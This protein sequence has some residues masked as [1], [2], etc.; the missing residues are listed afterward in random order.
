LPPE[1]QH[2]PEPQPDVG[3]RRAWLRLPTKGSRWLSAI[4]I[5]A[6]AYLYVFPLFNRVNNPNENVRFYMTA[7]IVED[8]TYH[9]DHVRERWG[10]VNDAAIYE[11]H[12]CSV[13]APATSMLGVPAY[14][15]YKEFAELRGVPFDRDVAL[16]ACRVFASVLPSLLFLYFYYE[17]LRRRGG[18]PVVRDAVFMSVAVGSMF[19][20]YAILFVTHTL[21][22]VAAFGA[23]MILRDARHRGTIG[24][25]SAWLAGFLA[26][27]I[28]ATEYP[29]APATAILCIYA[30]FCVRPLPRILSFGVG[31]L[32]PTLAVMHFHNSCYGSPF[33]PGH[34]FLEN[35]EFRDAMHEGFYGA[36]NIHWE[37]AGGLLFDPAYGLF[38]VT[39]ILFFAFFGVPRLLREKRDR[40]DVWFALAVCGATYAFICSVNNWR[41]GWTVGARY[42]ALTLPFVG[43][44]ALEGGRALVRASWM[45]RL[46]GAI[47][48][49]LLGG[50]ILLSG[51]PS[52]YYPHLPEAFTRPLPQ[53]V[54]WLVR[55]DYAP[56]N[57][58]RYF[59]AW[60]GSHSMVPLFIVGALA[61]LWPAWSERKW[62]DK[63]VVAIGSALIASWLITPFIAPDGTNEVAATD[64]RRFVME[65]WEPANEN[66]ISSVEERMREGRATARDL[67]RLPGLY[68]DEG[69]MNDVER[70]R[71]AVETYR[72]EHPTP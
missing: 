23:F 47:S 10:W 40:I 36:A 44:F 28:T 27:L 51:G 58:G 7:A 71:R 67:E 26:A 22:A 14:W 55:H 12:Y 54:R 16:W 66:L 41:G 11:G 18:E 4:A 25:G 17:W 15:A 57:A 34:R 32:I 43:W 3:P 45:P 19:Y 62:I 29:G 21:S 1:G 42:L 61:Y 5:C 35:D 13:K 64:A 70:A 50:G 38:M 56:F 60:T 39:P 30:L 9:I 33:R 59:F 52:A 53:L 72:Q 24:W 46:I 65:F 31:A 8:G 20:A 6:F 69:R 2:D 37:A 63:L 68:V 49:G 48:V